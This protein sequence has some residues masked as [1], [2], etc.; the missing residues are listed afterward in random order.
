ME[1]HLTVAISKM[2]TILNI[3]GTAQTTSSLGLSTLTSKLTKMQTQVWEGGRTIAQI[4][5]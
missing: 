5:I 4:G 1:L 3:T 2:Q